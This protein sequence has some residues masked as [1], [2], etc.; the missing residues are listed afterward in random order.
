MEL[1]GRAASTDDD[2]ELYT[3]GFNAWNQLVFEPSPAEEP[4]DIFTFTK[5]LTGKS[6]GRIVPDISWT[7]GN[8]HESLQ[9]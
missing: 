5:I 3:T 4:D 8:L 6:I 2:M 7:A 1:P 9:C